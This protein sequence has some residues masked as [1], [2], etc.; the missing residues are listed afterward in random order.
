MNRLTPGIGMKRNQTFYFQR[1]LGFLL[2]I[3]WFSNFASAQQVPSK[4]FSIESFSSGLQYLSGFSGDVASTQ[5]WPGEMGW[6]GD[7]ID[8]RFFLDSAY[9]PAE[10][11][12]FS[13]VMA[14]DDLGGLPVQEIRLSIAAGPD[15]GTLTAV[16]GPTLVE[17]PDLVVASI[18]SNAF[19]VNAWN[20][21]RLQGVD[22]EVGTGQSPGIKWYF[23]ALN[24]ERPVTEDAVRDD[25]L[26]RLVDYL[27]DA[28]LGNGLVRDALVLSPRQQ[29]FHP[30]SPDA[31]G[32]A[33]LGWSV[34]D[35]LGLVADADEKVRNIMAAYAG[36][37]QGVTPPRSAD[38]FWLRFMDVETGQGAVGWGDPCYT[39]IGSALLVTAAQFARSHF[40]ENAGISLLASEI[41]DSV[42]FDKA[43]APGGGV[44]IC[45]EASGGGQTVGCED[46]VCLAQPWN[47]F[48]LVVSAALRGENNTQATQFQDLWLDPAQLPKIG[49]EGISL[50]TDNPSAYPPAFWVQQ[51]HFFNWDFAGNAAFETFFEDQ[52]EADRFFSQEELL[53]DYR[54]GLTA[55]VV[56]TTCA[57]DD[58]QDGYNDDR[59]LDHCDVFSPEAVVG[60]GDLQA[61]VRFFLDQGN[62]NPLYRYGLLRASSENPQWFPN[63][64]GL[65]DHL[66]LMFGLMES[67]QPAF[68]KD[69]LRLAA[70][71]IFMDG[72]E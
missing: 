55:G 29:P 46:G 61:M 43:I 49:Y 30:A 3:L 70:T 5:T 72:F 15:G 34:A 44:Y 69:R 20:I 53:Q 58:E 23:W 32:F 25:Q 40:L 42:D 21:V 47:E 12:N 48:M 59:I 31:A 35:E 19:Q 68:F 41:K 17:G 60:W 10:T 8:V 52:Q 9:V 67:I 28:T 51:M 71:M 22:V 65:V 66:F 63:N 37:H 14:L 16:Y 13:W 26:H 56:P 2:C 36:Q 1:S 24:T 38:G 54:Y 27:D 33:I 4:I 57:A 7:R 62:Y 50:L 6:Q 64:A 39:T 11:T 45:M 18:P